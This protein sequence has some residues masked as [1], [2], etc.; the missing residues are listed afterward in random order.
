MK[1]LAF[2]L[3][4][5]FLLGFNYGCSR[6]CEESCR[7]FNSSKFC[8]RICEN[9][10][11]DPKWKFLGFDKLG[12][13]VF[14]YIEDTN[15][16]IVKVWE[17]GIYSERGKQSYIKYRIQ[18]KL[19]VIGYEN[20]DYNLTLYKIDCFKKRYQTLEFIDYASDGLILDDVNVPEFLA[21][22][23]EWSSI[24]PDSVI[25]GLFKK[26]CKIKE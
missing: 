20:F 23:S 10:I 13:A 26:V 8:K 5:L 15:Q 4:A 25:E 9:E 3:L 19:N 24:L 1:K 12:T 6:N 14:F 11:F 18:N 16:N 22:L 7:E 17:K 2:L 21:D